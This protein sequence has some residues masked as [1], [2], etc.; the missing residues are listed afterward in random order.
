MQKY[1]VTFK[2]KLTQKQVYTLEAESANEAQLIAESDDLDDYDV[3]I[4]ASPDL[5]WIGY[6]VVSVEEVK[7]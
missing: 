1:K 2:V 5:E 7:E 3:E 4:D 6:E